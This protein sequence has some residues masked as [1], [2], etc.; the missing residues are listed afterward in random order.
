MTPKEKANEFSEEAK[1]VFEDVREKVSDFT[2]E[3][4]ERIEEATEKTKS[5][6]QRLFGNKKS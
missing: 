6:F 4:G 3:A 5:F 1:E 2:E